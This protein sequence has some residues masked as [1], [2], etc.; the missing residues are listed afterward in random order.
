M[1]SLCCEPRHSSASLRW[2]PAH[3]WLPTKVAGAAASEPSG[4]VWEALRNG[5]ARPPRSTITAAAEAASQSLALD[6]RPATVAPSPAVGD[7]AR[8]RLCDRRLASGL[9][10]L[11]VKV[12]RLY[13]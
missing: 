12:F 5:S 9:G 1:A 7:A 8:V 13:T 2:Q 4:W 6:Q 10:R 11:R 3:A